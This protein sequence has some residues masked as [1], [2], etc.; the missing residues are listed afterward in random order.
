MVWNFCLFWTIVAYAS[1]RRSDAEIAVVGFLAAGLLI[2]LIA[3]LGIS[4][5]YNMPAL[6]ALL[7]KLPAPLLG[8]FQG[9]ESGFHPNQVAGTLVQVAPLGLAITVAD[10]VHRRRT[11]QSLPLSL[12]VWCSTAVIATVLLLTQSRAA[13]LGLSAAVAVMVLVN[14][15][16]GRWILL[17]LLVVLSVMAYYVPMQAL[18]QLISSAP[19]QAIGGGNTLG[20]RQEVWHQAIALLRQFPLTGVGFGAFREVLFVYAST[21]LSPSYNLGHAHNFFLQ[22][23]LDFGLPGLIALVAVY[24]LAIVQILSMLKESKPVSRRVFRAWKSVLAVGLL[25]CIVG[26]ATY[27]MLDTVAMG[28]KTNF[29]FWYQFALV[30]GVSLLAAEDGNVL[31]DEATSNL[32]QGELAQSGALQE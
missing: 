30:F 7:I 16:W 15:R 29:I 3:P 23:A 11:L 26:Q 5:P 12:L 1:R 21:T 18:E 2:A 17:A 4:W 10:M 20:F 9:A 32:V 6:H 8:T 28:A 27:G 14:W 31:T 19:A 13:M 22:T 24:M 25:G